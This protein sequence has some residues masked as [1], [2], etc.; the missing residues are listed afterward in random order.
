MEV[1]FGFHRFGLTTSRAVYP[2][3]VA[4]IL[5]ESKAQLKP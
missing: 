2:A 4:A 1:R 5:A 3:M